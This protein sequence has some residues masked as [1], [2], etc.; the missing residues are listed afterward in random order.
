M[1]L[2]LGVHNTWIFECSQ[3]DS[4]VRQTGSV[5]TTL[6]S[7]VLLFSL[8]GSA[9][10]VSA[11]ATV[12]D[13]G[14]ETGVISM[15][16]TTPA[17]SN[18]ST[19]RHAHPDRVD[20]NGDTEQVTRW[21]EGRLSADLEASAIEISQG[22]YQQA[23]ATFGSEFDSR[24]EQ[25]VEVAG[26]TD[27]TA[28]D[29]T[30]ETIRELRQTQQAY[31]NA[32][33][34]YEE[35]YDDYQQARANG[36]ETAAR[37]AAR[38][39]ES[40]A[41]RIKTYN[42]TLVRN[43]EALETQANVST[44]DAK[45]SVRTTSKEVTTRQESV[46]SQTFTTTGL[47]VSAPESAVSFSEP[48]HITGRLTTVNGT[49]ITNRT[50]HLRVFQR[51]YTTSTNATGGFTVAYRP[52]LLPINATTI[53]VRYLPN[54]ASPYLGSSGNVSA[55]VTQVSPT[56]TTTTTPTTSGYGDQITTQAS[57]TVNGRPV[58]LLALNASLGRTVVDSETDTSGNAMFSQRIPLTLPTGQHSVSVAHEQSGLAIG[59]ASV[60]EPITVTQTPTRITT[61]ATAT[62]RRVL[63]RGRLETMN[64][65]GIEQQPVSVTV[66]ENRTS[67]RT[68][69]SGWYRLSVDNV[70]AAEDGINSSVA[71]AVVFRGRGTNL[72]GAR[73]DTTVSVAPRQAGNGDGHAVTNIVL[74]GIVGLGL[75][76]A[77]LWRTRDEGSDADRSQQTPQTST[78]DSI[79]SA[80]LSVQQKLSRARAA[81]EDGN[82]ESAVVAAYSA[83]REQVE[84]DIDTSNPLTYREFLTVAASTRDATNQ[85][86][87][88]ILADAYERAIFAPS[89]EMATAKNAIEAAADFLSIL[90]EP[91]DSADEASI[92]DGSD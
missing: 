62:G 92:G 38:Q 73:A 76:G 81:L 80:E 30:A 21:L 82:A 39:L 87:M 79:E 59:P 6:V 14:H 11:H 75:L 7:A 27:G 42:T 4:G 47:R 77:L 29:E 60:T 18:N 22:Q 54:G 24:L 26:Q 16:Q 78:A 88:S 34:A 49:A 12:Q 57:V 90:N 53:P 40:Q 9:G 36:N 41:E 66:G 56:L 48:L 70:I 20:E 13:Q 64:G 28:D 71:V 84:G 55:A 3:L 86:E 58:P 68:N 85:S 25:Y 89:L 67:V 15:Q 32:S 65:T 61:E 33:Q 1:I 83:V 45:T 50:V 63:V 52:V 43:Y 35:A 91:Q 46:R 23:E 69:R 2:T 8:I 10:V 31:A 19:L 37:E 74:V 44:T 51:T 72:D 17:P 5:S